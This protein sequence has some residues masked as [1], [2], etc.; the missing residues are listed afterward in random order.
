M[1][2]EIGIPFRGSIPSP[3]LH[4]GIVAPKV[5]GHGCATNRAARNQ[6]GGDFRIL[7][8]GKHLPDFRLIVIGLV[9]AGLGTLPQTVISLGVEQTAFVKACPLE[10]VIHIGGQ[11]KIVLVLQ[12]RQ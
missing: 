6:L 5:H 2:Q 9:V 7:L 4:E 1:P 11:H 3:I 12:Q 8:L 10:L